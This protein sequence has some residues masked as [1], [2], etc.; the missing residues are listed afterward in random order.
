MWSIKF[1][2]IVA[3]V[4]HILLASKSI[5]P[6]A[7]SDKFPQLDRSG[8]RSVDQRATVDKNG[9]LIEWDDEDPSYP[10]DPT[11]PKD[12]SYIIT[13]SSQDNKLKNEPTGF[14]EHNPKRSDYDEIEPQSLAYNKYRAFNDQNPTW[15]ALGVKLDK[16]ALMSPR[17]DETPNDLVAPNHSPSWWDRFK[18]SDSKSTPTS[19]QPENPIPTRRPEYEFNWKP[20]IQ[21][22]KIKVVEPINQTNYEPLNQPNR[23]SFENIVI[24][25]DSKWKPIK[26]N[27]QANEISSIENKVTNQN[28]VD[29]NTSKLQL[30]SKI[31]DDVGVIYGHR[32]M[33]TLNYNIASDINEPF[34]D[35]GIIVSRSPRSRDFADTDH[36]R[37]I[38]GSK[39]SFVSQK[40]DNRWLPIDGSNNFLTSNITNNNTELSPKPSDINYVYSSQPITASQAEW[41]PVSRQPMTN[42][43]SNYQIPSLPPNSNDQPPVGIIDTTSG[44]TPELIS[45]DRVPEVPNQPSPQATLLPDSGY[46][47]YTSPYAQPQPQPQPQPQAQP[48]PQLDT[49]IQPSNSGYQVNQAT[50]SFPPTRQIVATSTPLRQSPQPSS[51]VLRQ[52]HHYHYY[53]Q[54]QPQ[55]QQR[56]TSQ[57]PIVRDLP[58]LVIS[59]PIIQQSAPAPAPAPTTSTTTPSPP[60][61]QIIREVIKEV[62]VM[63]IQLSRVIQMPPAPSIPMPAPV[64]VPSPAVMIQSPARQIIRQ[65]SNSMPT[66]SMRIPQI[67]PITQI[68]LPLPIRLAASTSQPSNPAPVTRQ[69]G[70]FITPPVPKKTTT[71]LTQTQ[72]VPT[73][74]TIMHSTQ[75]TP[76]TRTTVYTTEHHQEPQSYSSSSAY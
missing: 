32:S 38:M 2:I 66:V 72:A 47:Y 55:Q 46:D 6:A 54:Q 70:S 9:K 31:A 50:V 1:K 35:D 7:T 73:H 25:N 41:P 8:W 40:T 36:E 53:Q 18:R 30:A 75:Y 15:K 42:G 19:N 48:I 39:F 23:I 52:E 37:E 5:E 29:D 74:T 69:T 24:L 67:A 76:A 17:Q 60:P 20:L 21:A 57:A 71:Y 64:M 59:Q 3:C 45:L 33:D 49:G 14:V 61:Q 11:N 63:P 62:P 26:D 16:P 44:Q 58:P 27:K 34:D 56:Q 28:I 22:P 68:R 43:Y 51:Q 65:I 10:T 13:F 12:S 4:C